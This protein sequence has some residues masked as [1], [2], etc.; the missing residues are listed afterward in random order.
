M[1]TGVGAVVSRAG[2][3]GQYGFMVKL[4][5]A[6]VVRPGD[7][8]SGA[9]SYAGV[10]RVLGLV[11]SPRGHAIY[12]AG[13]A[14]GSV[15][16]VCAELGDPAAVQAS[17]VSGEADLPEVLGSQ[18][19]GEQLITGGQWQG[20]GH[21]DLLP[22]RDRGAVNASGQPLGEFCRG[23]GAVDAG[24]ELIDHPSARVVVSARSRRLEGVRVWNASADRY[25]VARLDEVMD[26]PM[27]QTVRESVARELAETA[28]GVIWKAP[29]QAR[30]EDYEVAFAVSE[31]LLEP[32][33]FLLTVI[34]AVARAAAVHAGFGPL[35]G[36]VGQLTEV[37]C[38]QL[39]EPGTEDQL[40]SDI[41]TVL[42]IDLYASKLV[43]LPGSALG[44]QAGRTAIAAIDNLL[45]S[46]PETRTAIPERGQGPG[47]PA[48]YVGDASGRG[49]E[50]MNKL[51]ITPLTMPRR[52]R[53][54]PGP[55][56]GGR[57]R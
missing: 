4:Y 57:G 32:Q 36:L 53:G 11:P 8:S 33:E 13:T 26:E 42:D 31:F 30:S 5:R 47:T 41:V 56:R 49:E 55:E 34:N 23:K 20:I 7:L 9:G 14:P 37:L 19:M 15:T 24:R 48:R 29:V 21:A 50:A 1:Q 12:L 40:T 43:P 52:G 35:A 17:D 28:V 6:L 54:R 51:G 18:R 39:I 2:S 16:L 45:A 46:R 44:R 25:A 10:C 3:G 38:Q 27:R 22:G